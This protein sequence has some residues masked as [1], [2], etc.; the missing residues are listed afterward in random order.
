MKNLNKEAV[1]PRTLV[2]PH[3][4]GFDVLMIS[5]IKMCQPNGYCTNFFVAGN[6]KY[7]S[8]KNLKHFDEMLEELNIIRVHHSY[9]VN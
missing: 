7:T 5:E 9:L 8:S 1:L 3:L 4:K 2:I 6:R